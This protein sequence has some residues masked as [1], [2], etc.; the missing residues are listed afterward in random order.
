M[1]VLEATITLR[2]THSKIE[3]DLVYVS[4][5]P[6]ETG[7]HLSQPGTPL[8]SNAIHE[9]TPPPLEMMIFSPGKKFTFHFTLTSIFCSLQ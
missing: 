7:G 2:D 8:G 5:T 3:L 1:S 6:M 4:G 9:A